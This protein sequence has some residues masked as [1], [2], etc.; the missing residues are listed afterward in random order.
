MNSSDSFDRNLSEWLHADAEHRVP[1]HL[2][3]VLRR[4]RTERQRPAWSS[5][6]RWLPVQTTLRLSPVPRVAWL[7]LVLALLLALAV[8]IL[9]VGSRP[10]LPEPFGLARNGAVVT[11]SDGDIYSI[12]ATTGT[13][14]AL[15]ADPAFDFG[16]TFSRDGTKFIF[17]RGAAPGQPDLG[18]ELVVADSDGTNVHSVSPF[19]QGLD[20]QD[21]SPDSTKIAF[22]SRP[23]SGSSAPG[24]INIVNADGTGLR[25]LDVGRPA[26][27]L[28]WLPPDGKEI[29]FRGEQLVESDALPGIFAVRPDG[30]GLRRISTRPALNHN[31]YQDITV[32][33]DG[34]QVT[35]RDA[36][37]VFRVHVFDLQTGYD[38]P[39]PDPTGSTAQMGGVFSPDGRSIVYQRF[40]DQQTTQLVVAPA[41]GSGTGT[42]IGTPTAVGSDGPVFNNYAFTPDGKA[43]VVNQ[44]D[45]VTRLFPI[46]GSAGEIVAT[47]ANAFAAYQR[48]AP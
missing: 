39:L 28:S 25:T 26:H 14:K 31:D 13:K 29:I 19:V 15:V 17:L 22:L 12:D 23:T 43:V 37:D 32:S 21:W 34:R 6:E 1:D 33:P 24:V 40:I 47:G 30:T 48:L 9:A 20:W 10:R 2:D 8:A 45:T 16:P 35:Y 5:L 46:D 41:D 38:L 11:S 7:L 42:P 18:L 44:G 3:A 4:T 27:E 36:G